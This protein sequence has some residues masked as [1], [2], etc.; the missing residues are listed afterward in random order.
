MQCH[1]RE[2]REVRTRTAPYPPVKLEDNNLEQDPDSASGP[3][4]PVWCSF[5]HDVDES[6]SL[7]CRDTKTIHMR[8]LFPLGPLA[9]CP[10]TVSCSYRP[11]I[12]DH[13]TVCRKRYT[14]RILF[15]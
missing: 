9:S 13:V 10:E 15:K 3:L 2:S 8:K 12:S 11:V 6:T 14:C 7:P 5:R 1:F 4:L